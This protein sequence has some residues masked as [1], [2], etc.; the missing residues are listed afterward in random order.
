MTIYLPNET[1]DRLVTALAN[2]EPSAWSGVVTASEIIEVLGE[3]ALIF[4]A[5]TEH[6]D[7]GAE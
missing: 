6:D 1:Y 7:V 5:W 3:E 4:P 2:V